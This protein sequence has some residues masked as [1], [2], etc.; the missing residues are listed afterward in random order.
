MAS[1]P[2]Y[3]DSSPAISKMGNF[4]SNPAAF[5]TK[6]FNISPRAAEAMDPQQRILLHV[7][8]E[9][10]E[11]AGYVPDS[12]EG[13][14]RERFGCFIGA[15]TGDWADCLREQAGLYHSTGTRMP[16]TYCKG[17]ICYALGTFRAF[18]SGR[19]SHFLKWGG[20]SIA[21]DTAC[22]SSIVAI[23]QACRALQNGDCNAALAGGVNIICSPDVGLSRCLH[24]KD[25]IDF[26]PCRTL[27]V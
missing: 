16:P 2:T 25:L 22:S 26:L 24:D 17:L 8:H 14:K 19:I 23:Y 12:T 3:S 5:D 1:I 6:F 13:W 21:V 27:P 18:L 20:P 4:L 7:T 15:A 9:A 11:N 10:L